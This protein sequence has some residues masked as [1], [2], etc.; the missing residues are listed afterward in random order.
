MLRW[1]GCWP[2][3]LL[4]VAAQT[5]GPAAFVR[6]RA[7]QQPPGPATQP[8]KQA[9]RAHNNNSDTNNHSDAAAAAAAAALAVAMAVAVAVVVICQVTPKTK[10]SIRLL[11]AR[12]TA[13]TLLDARPRSRRVGRPD[14]PRRAALRVPRWRL[15]VVVVICQVTPKK[16]K[17]IRRCLRAVPAPTAGFGRASS[18]DPS[19]FARLPLLAQQLRRPWRW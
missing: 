2:P 17:S 4:V 13:A 9:P 8:A 15:A 6:T 14:W 19:P 5:A 1:L 12:T 18:G 10:K 3:G 11:L 7:D 16:Q